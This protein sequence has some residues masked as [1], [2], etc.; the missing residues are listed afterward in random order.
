M[1]DKK[2]PQEE[3]DISNR[4]ARETGVI[5]LRACEEA[6]MSPPAML[7]TLEGII[8]NIMAATAMALAPEAD[9]IRFATEMSEALLTESR[10][11]VVGFL[12]DK[13]Y[14]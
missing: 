12:K 6:D 10:K 1:T 9:P 7:V 11:R 3:A 4:I 8:T 2:S 14:K 13:G 5:F